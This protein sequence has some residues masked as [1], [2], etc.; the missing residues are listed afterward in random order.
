MD[1]IVIG[2]M[3]KFDKKRAQVVHINAY[4]CIAS[5]IEKIYTIDGNIWLI[6]FFIFYS[7]L[8]LSVLSDR[9]SVPRVALYVH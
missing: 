9:M 1:K 8:S 5:K 2:D 7:L 3:F 6:S 4:V